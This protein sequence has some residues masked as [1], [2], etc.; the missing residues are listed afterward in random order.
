MTLLFCGIPMGFG[1]LPVVGFFSMIV[2]AVAFAMPMKHPR[3]FPGVAVTRDAGE[4]N[5]S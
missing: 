2:R 4:K 1:L 3:F 5:H